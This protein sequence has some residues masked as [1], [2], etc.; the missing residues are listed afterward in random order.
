MNQTEVMFCLL[1]NEI[2]GEA[3][4]D[5]LEY[6]VDKLI[7]LSKKHDVAHLIADAL[8]NNGIITAE[9]KDYKKIRKEKMLAVYRCEQQQYE[10]ER[11]GLV[12]ESDYITYIPLKGAVMRNLYPQPWMR[13]SCDIDILIK[14]CDVDKA[15][16]LLTE[17]LGYKS[18]F[19]NAHDISLFSKNGVHVELHFALIDETIVA[20]GEDVLS[21]VWDFVDDKREGCLKSL[22]DGVFYLYHIEH[23]AKHLK[24]GG[25]GIRP[26]I[27]VWVLNNLIEFDAELRDDLL[28]RSGLADFEK[29]VKR[30]SEVWFGGYPSDDTMMKLGRFILEGGVYGNVENKVAVNDEE[31]SKNSFFRKLFKPYDQ[32]KF[33][34]PILIKHKWLMPLCQVARWFRIL[35]KGAVKSTVAE[36]RALKNVSREKAEEISAL[37]KAI[38]L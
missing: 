19:I 11:I 6:D 27:D 24:N 3:L 20:G 28:V 25:C 14:E 29:T 7:E 13:T 34:Y 5:N 21:R 23:T 1:K 15:V 16:N 12:F 8:I 35:F 36:K 9:Y 37:M 33:W 22:S 30:L 38:G 4:P 17:N 26:I 2:R 18:Q 31:P 32:L 10:L